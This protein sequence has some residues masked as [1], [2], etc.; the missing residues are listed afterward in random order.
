MAVGVLPNPEAIIS[1]TCL[2]VGGLIQAYY[3]LSEVGNM[4]Q[5][6]TFEILIRQKAQFRVTLGPGGSVWNMDA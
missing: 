1:V 6:M 3:N 5:Q 4:R 2:G